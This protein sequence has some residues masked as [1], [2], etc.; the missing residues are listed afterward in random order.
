VAKLFYFSSIM[1]SIERLTYILDDL[2]EIP[3]IKRR[4]GLD[5]II[6][7][8]PGFGELITLMLSTVP[9]YY[10]LKEGAP[11]SVILR[12]LLN[13]TIDTGIGLIPFLGDIFDFMFKS[14]RRNLNL[15]KEWRLNPDHVAKKTTWMFALV[16]GI[17]FLIMTGFL[18][19][20]V[21][22]IKELGILINSYF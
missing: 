4:V 6:G 19:L 17:L 12:M 18:Y 21:V 16:L 13:T 15:F 7:L 14:N 9:I 8:V 5:P 10:A 11:L 1:E 3:V 22:V 2:F 20:S